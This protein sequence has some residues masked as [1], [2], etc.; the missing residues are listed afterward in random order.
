MPTRPL[1]PHETPPI[2]LELHGKWIAW[3]SAHTEIVAHS[4]SLQH[5]WQ[6]VREQNVHDPVFEKVPR[7]DVRFVGVR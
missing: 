2:P 5:L 6:T 7:A 4:D 1:R 3:N